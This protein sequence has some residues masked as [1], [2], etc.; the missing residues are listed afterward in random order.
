LKIVGD[1]K[2]NNSNSLF[3]RSQYVIVLTAGTAVADGAYD[4]SVANG[5][6]DTSGN[7]NPAGRFSSSNGYSWAVIPGGV[8]QFAIDATAVP[9]PC[10]LALSGLGGLLFLWH[11]RKSK[12][13]L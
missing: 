8:F 12:V 6:Y 1:I 13:V 11:R 2:T 4:W 10:V 5:S 9:E 3:Q 7:W